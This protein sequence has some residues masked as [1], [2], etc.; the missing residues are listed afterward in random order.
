M[1][2]RRNPTT[3]RRIVLL[4]NREMTEAI[5]VAAARARVSA[6]TIILQQLAR[7]GVIAAE[8]PAVRARL[9]AQQPKTESAA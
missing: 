3:P 9:A 6:P 5:D 1:G 7:S 4:P 2:M 8:L